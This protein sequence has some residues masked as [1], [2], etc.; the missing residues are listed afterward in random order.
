MVKLAPKDTQRFVSGPLLR[1]EITGGTSFDYL[2]GTLAEINGI[3]SLAQKY[4]IPVKLYKGTA[5]MEETY[6]RFGLGP[7][8]KII[9]IATHGFF[10]PDPK[11][12]YKNDHALSSLG[13]QQFSLS[14]NPLNRAGLLFAGANHV[15]QAEVIPPGLED[16][17]LT[18]YEASNVP[19]SSTEL[20]VLSACETGLGDIK[21]SEGVF[22]LQRAFK[23][24]GATYLLMS[25]WQVPD[26]E[27]AE[28]MKSFYSYLFS[29]NTVEMAFIFSQSAMKKKYRNDP[30]KWAAFV[31]MR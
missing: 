21:G 30:H 12:E 2:P 26:I 8:P 10:F 19:L 17:V 4:H 25:L 3:D 27:T 11:E 1:S 23:A 13:K 24:A 22:G 9:H 31:L 6:K 28:F 29:G 7:S 16:G 18:A 14:E 20:V 15:W 5:A